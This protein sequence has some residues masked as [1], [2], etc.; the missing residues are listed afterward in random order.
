MNKTKGFLFAAGMVLAMVFTFSC[1]SDGGSG[2][3][4]SSSGNEEPSSSSSVPSSSGGDNTCSADLEEVQIGSQIWA[5][6]NL[7]CDVEGSKCYENKPENCEKYGRLYNW[8]TFKTV[9]PAGW[10]LPSRA[11]TAFLTVS[12]PAEPAASGGL[13]VI[14]MRA[15]ATT[16]PAWA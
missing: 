12:V 8:E 9:C 5:K 16:T 2:G 3:D 1:S 10:H 15:I 6:K 14:P 7:N 13:V 4:P 11:A